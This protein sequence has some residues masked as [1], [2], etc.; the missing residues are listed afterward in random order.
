[1]QLVSKRN[2]LFIMSLFVG[3]YILLLVISSYYNYN[4]D[5]LRVLLEIITIPVVLMQVPV[6]ILAVRR[7]IKKD[8]NFYNWA[9]FLLMALSITFTIIS[10]IK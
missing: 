2:Y 5:S 8:Y 3:G 10:F 1:M 6:F 9:A 4:L 7:L